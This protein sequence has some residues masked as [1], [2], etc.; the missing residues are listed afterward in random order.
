LKGEVVVQC[1]DPKKNKCFAEVVIP[2]SNFTNNEQ[3]QVDKWFKLKST[4]SSSSSAGELR[5]GLQY[6][7]LKVRIVR[8]P[9]QQQQQQQQKSERKTHFFSSHSPEAT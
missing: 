3:M 4:S 7:S 2:L 9:K 5:L 8:V 6:T 1:W